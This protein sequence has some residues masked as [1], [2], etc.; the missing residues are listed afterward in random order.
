MLVSC[1]G[2][3]FCLNIA[4]THVLFYWTIETKSCNKNRGWFLRSVTMT[5]C[6]QTQENRL[7]FPGLARWRE[8][9]K[10]PLYR[11]N[12][13]GGFLHVVRLQAAQ[14][15]MHWA[16]RFAVKVCKQH[17][18]YF[19]PPPGLRH[20]QTKRRAMQACSFI[21]PAVPLW[22]PRGPNWRPPRRSC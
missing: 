22:F 11:N 8:S 4:S 13:T 21:C 16:M 18:F 7:I 9:P 14:R 2:H 15:K 5:G 10:N 3:C 1:D 20:A 12:G 6:L 17:P 19:G